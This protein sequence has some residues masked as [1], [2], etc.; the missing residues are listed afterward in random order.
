VSSGLD[1]PEAL[2]MNAVTSA[3]ARGEGSEWGERRDPGNEVSSWG[4]RQE[5]IKP[6]PYTPVPGSVK[7]LT[8]MHHGL[9]NTEWV[10]V[11]DKLVISS[12]CSWGFK[13]IKEL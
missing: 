13:V 4:S 1:R 7:T 12:S 5:P 8:L 10:F 2:Q 6:A 9:A 3:A 11:R